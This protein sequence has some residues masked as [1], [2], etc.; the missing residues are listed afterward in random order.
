M[1]T[2][3]IGGDESLSIV[4]S[5]DGNTKILNGISFGDPKSSLIDIGNVNDNIYNIQCDI[6]EA[7]YSSDTN[8]VKNKILEIDNSTE[9][10]ERHIDYLYFRIRECNHQRKLT[11]R[12]KMKAYIYRVSYIIS[13]IIISLFYIIA[14]LAPKSW[15][16]E[17]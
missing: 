9:V 2:S 4:F 11:R 14:K 1:K 5:D 15:K 13:K 16:Q 17:A 6:K 12:L 7:M 10:L 3:P 8:A